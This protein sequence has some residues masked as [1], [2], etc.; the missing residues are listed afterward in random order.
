PDLAPPAL[1]RTGLPRLPLLVGRVAPGRPGA[2]GGDVVGGSRI[3]CQLQ[4]SARRR[5]RDAV[6]ELLLGRA[7][8]PRALPRAL[9]RVRARADVDLAAQSRHAEVTKLPRLYVVML[10]YRIAAMVA[11]FML[12][13]AAREARLELGPRYLWAALAL[14]SSYVAA[15]AL[16]DLADEEIDKVNH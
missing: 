10:R 15:T 3:R 6:H 9:G 8:L 7:L 14:A 11:M 16:N 4:T 1:R 12:L 5:R 2:C 13:G